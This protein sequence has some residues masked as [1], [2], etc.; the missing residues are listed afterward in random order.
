MEEFK[1]QRAIRSFRGTSP[2]GPG[3]IFPLLCPVREYEWVPG[4]VCDLVYAPSGFGETGGVFLTDFEDSGPMTW[5]I[6]KRDAEEKCFHALIKAGGN[7]LVK[8]EVKVEGNLDGTSILDWTRTLTGLTP[9]GN[10]MIAQQTDEAYR[11]SME[12]LTRELN[13]Y[14]VAGRMLDGPGRVSR[15]PGLVRPPE[16][17]VRKEWSTVFFS[18]AAPGRVF[19]L[20]CPT[21][22][23]EW[24]DDWDC[25]LIFSESGFAENNCVFTTDFPG[26]GPAVWAV[27]RYEPDRAIEFVLFYRDAWVLKFEIHLEEAPGGTRVEW[28]HIHTGLSPEGNSYLEGLTRGHFKAEV[29][30]LEKMINHFLTS[31]DMLKR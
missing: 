25:R 1:A 21:R 31:G 13:H 27:S 20:L 3:A 11:E 24:I 12:K 7:F 8:L 5:V 26:E 29:D 22:E 28:R 18:P 30:L 6:T 14:L 23:Y 4:W 16:T 9:R 15:R 2:A 10:A 17:V 19:P